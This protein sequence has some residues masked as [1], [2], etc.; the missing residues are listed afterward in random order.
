MIH[1]RKMCKEF[2][3]VKIDGKNTYVLLKFHCSLSSFKDFNFS[4]ARSEVP[5][6]SLT[7]EFFP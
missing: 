3:T 6:F 2:Y 5:D 4:L 7:V 1:D